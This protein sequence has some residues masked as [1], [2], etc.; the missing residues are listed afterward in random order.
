MAENTTE[1]PGLFERFTNYL[2]D[3]FTSATEG[4]GSKIDEFVDGVKNGIGELISDLNPLNMVRDALGNMMAPVVDFLRG[5]VEFIQ[6]AVKW[7]TGNDSTFGNEFLHSLESLSGTPDEP[8]PDAAVA[9][10]APAPAVAP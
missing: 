4:V 10:A 3:S 8:V 9:P 7:A 2:S 6:G 5:I 1:E